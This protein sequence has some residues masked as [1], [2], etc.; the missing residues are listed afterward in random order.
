MAGTSYSGDDQDSNQEAW[1]W[2]VCLSCPLRIYFCRT[3]DF[4][5]GRDPDYCDLVLEEKVLSTIDRDFN[6]ENFVRLS[7]IHF[8]IGKALGEERAALTDL[9]S[10]GTLVDGVK[11][12]KDDGAF[13]D[14]VAVQLGVPRR[15]VRDGE[16]HDAGETQHLVQASLGQR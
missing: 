12:D 14:G 15:A 11:V 6:E 3:A 16:R 4:V 2:L 5:I 1:G 10:N 13:G 8:K 7:R 9:S